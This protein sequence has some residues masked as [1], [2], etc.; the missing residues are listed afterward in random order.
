MGEQ[1]DLFS[2]LLVWCFRVNSMERLLLFDLE[3]SE[4]SRAF[5]LLVYFICPMTMLL[6]GLFVPGQSSASNKPQ[7]VKC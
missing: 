6:N 1:L 5:K 4:M 7:L 2:C 3:G